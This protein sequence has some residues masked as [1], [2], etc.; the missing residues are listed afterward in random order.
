MWGDLL[1]CTGGALKPEKCFWYLVD[2]E[3]KEGEWQYT[4]MVDWELH[5]TQI[6]GDI[7]GYI[8]YMT[9]STTIRWSNIWLYKEGLSYIYNHL[10]ITS[11][12]LE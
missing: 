7:V 6:A 2:Y 12:E 8:T 11:T 3:C 9:N 10:Y 1:C 5:C 4:D